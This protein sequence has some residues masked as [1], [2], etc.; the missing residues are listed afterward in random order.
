MLL[1]QPR[2]RYPENA[3]SPPNLA[4]AESNGPALTPVYVDTADLAVD[5][6]TA[7]GEVPRSMIRR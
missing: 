5:I 7:S 2:F 4:E 6:R 3:A 1:Y